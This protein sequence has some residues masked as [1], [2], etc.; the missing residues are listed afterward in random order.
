MQAFKKKEKKIS[1]KMINL[2]NKISIITGKLSYF[3]EKKT[4]ILY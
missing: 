2:S 1:I 4:T 3:K